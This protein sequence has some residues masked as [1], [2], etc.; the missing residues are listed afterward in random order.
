MFGSVGAVLVMNPLLPQKTLIFLLISLGLITLPHSQHLPVPLFMFFCFLWGWRFIAIWKPA[1]LPGK[2]I[3]FLLTVTSLVLLYTQQI[4]LFGR[5]GGT[6]IF[7]TALG[8]KLLEI[9]SSRDIYF[10]TY[11]SVHDKKY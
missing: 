2:F 8:L 11:F 5:D 4:K 10:I 9:R 1:W 7:V 3:I 6:A